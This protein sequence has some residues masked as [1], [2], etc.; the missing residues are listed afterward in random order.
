MSFVLKTLER[1]IDRHIRD[2]VLISR[3]IHKL[4]FAY[5]PGKSTEAVLHHLVSKIENTFD[6]K[7]VALGV[8]LDIEGAFDNTSFTY[9]TQQAEKHG[10]SSSLTRWIGH[11]LSSREVS[12][13]LFDETV[14]IKTTRGF[15][16]GGCLSPLPWCLVINGLIEKLNSLGSYTQGFADDISLYNSGS[17]ESAVYEL[18][19]RSLGVVEEW[20]QESGLLVNPSKTSVVRFTKRRKLTDVN[21]KLF[22]QSLKLD[23]TVKYLGVTIDS[24][25]TWLPHL[26]CVTE[27][28]TRSFWACRSMVGRTW[29]EMARWL[30]NQVILPRITYG[31]TVWWPAVNKV[32]CISKLNSIQRMANLTITGAMRSTPSAA[33]DVLVG[34]LPLH[35]KVREV[36]LSGAQRL[37]RLNLWCDRLSS[38]GHT[39][40]LKSCQ[41]EWPK[42]RNSDNQIVKYYFERMFEVAFPERSEWTEGSWHSRKTRSSSTLTPLKMVTV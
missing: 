2:I 37:I 38:P 20:C 19:Q 9:I 41:S 36:T 14:T 31:A 30:Y 34:L 25:L 6:R 11:M 16:Q 12:A 39:Q 13:R 7:E 26:S 32:T 40:I 28:A 17:C 22:N 8:F 42:W 23:K 33:M 4:Q 10:I 21:L 35:I 24:T 29:P 3:P 15:P 18:T 27:K 1:L 5:Q